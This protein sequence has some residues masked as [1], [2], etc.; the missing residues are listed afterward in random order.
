MQVGNKK[1]RTSWERFS[2]IVEDRNN[3]FELSVVFHDWQQKVSM[4]IFCY[5]ATLY[6]MFHEELHVLY[7]HSSLH[8][9][10]YVY[11]YVCTSKFLTSLHLFISSFLLL[12]LPR[13]SYLLSSPPFSLLSFSLSL[14]LS[15]SSLF[16]LLT[17]SSSPPHPLLSSPP[18]PLLP[19]VLPPY[20]CVE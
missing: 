14:S 17:H 7:C 3:M 16:T 9:H 12:S 20:R 15:L 13:F 18:L 6:C 8:I 10:I 11:L 5:S 1:L 2:R 4:Q 19:P